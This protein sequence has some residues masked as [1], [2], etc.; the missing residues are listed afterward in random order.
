MAEVQS[1][2]RQDNTFGLMCIGQWGILS[3]LIDTQAKQTHSTQAGTA[4]RQ[5]ESTREKWK[6]ANELLTN[7]TN[8]GESF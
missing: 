2:T 4:A 3:L 5:G 6:G 8:E 7:A 1:T